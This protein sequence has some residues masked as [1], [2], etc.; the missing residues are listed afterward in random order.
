[1]THSLSCL[2]IAV[3]IA[4]DVAFAVVVA[5]SR[6]FYKSNFFVAAFTIAIAE[7][8]KSTIHESN[9]IIYIAA[10]DVAVA[11]AIAIAIAIR[12][13]RI[14]PNV[15]HLLRVENGDPIPVETDKVPASEFQFF[16]HPLA[17]LAIASAFAVAILIDRIPPNVKHLQRVESGDPL[18]VET[19]KVPAS[20]F[21]FSIH[22][23]AKLAIA[24]TV[25]IAIAV[26]VAAKIARFLR[27]M[28]TELGFPQLKLTRIF[29]DNAS[30]IRIVNARVP[31]GRTRHIDIR[32]F[33]IQGWKEQ[34]DIILHYIPGIINPSDDLTKP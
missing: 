20:E 32:F 22:P 13:D 27:S 17:K 33:A 23:F 6:W 10:G 24:V 28:I 4:I 16:I 19:D 25:A 21:Q 1:L 30:T 2:A 15:Q 8:Y 18:P 5:T 26:T 14:P 11:V 7:F 3:A 9:F 34:G 12:I 31:A 29:E